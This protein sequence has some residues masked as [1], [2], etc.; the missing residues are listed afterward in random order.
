MS[1]NP[2][3]YE[4]Q[5]VLILGRGNKQNIKRSFFQKLYGVVFMYEKYP[6]LAASS[7]YVYW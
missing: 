6:H 1:T 5:T 7:N 2:D 3:D 4:G